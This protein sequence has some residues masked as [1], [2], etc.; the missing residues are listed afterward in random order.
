MTLCHRVFPRKIGTGIVETPNTTKR[1]NDRFTLVL[2][3]IKLLHNNKQLYPCF[4]LRKIYENQKR[5]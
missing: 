5:D 1:S 2:V 4:C 3:K